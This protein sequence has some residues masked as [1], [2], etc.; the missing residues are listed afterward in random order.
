M[1]ASR[2]RPLLSPPSQALLV[3]LSF[4]GIYLSFPTANYSYDA[5]GYVGFIHQGTFQGPGPGA[6]HPYHVLYM[7]MGIALGRTVLALGVLPDVLAMMQIVNALFAAATLAVFFAIVRAETGRPAA[8]LVATGLL[9]FAYSFWYY[10][11][12]PEVYPPCL[13]FL[14]L[15]WSCARREGVAAAAASGLCFGVASGFH[16]AA[17]AIAPAIAVA[18]LAP[19]PGRAPRLRRLAAA[20]A[21]VLVVGLAPYA[22][23]FHLREGTTLAAGLAR[24][25]GEAAS[26]RSESGEAWFLGRG[27]HPWMEAQGTLAGFS[28][29]LPGGPLAAAGTVLRWALAG[30][31]ILVALH[32]PSLWRR[33]RTAT[34]VLAL[35]FASSFV[36]FTAY[37]VGSLKFVSFH[38]IPLLLLAGLTL[39]RLA[40]RPAVGA[41]V[42]P[43]GAGLVGLLLAVNLAGS[44]LPGMRPERNLPYRRAL[45]VRDRTEAA[46]L[47][48]QAGL[49]ENVELKVYLPYFAARRAVS[50]DLLLRGREP[51]EALAVLDAAIRAAAAGGGRAFVLSDLLDDPAVQRRFGER[52]RLS[53]GALTSFFARYR[54][55]PHASAEDSFGLYELAAPAPA[56]DRGAGR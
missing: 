11:T 55:R 49:G 45:F 7:P 12:D 26:R 8:A 4:L 46:D 21:A 32:G 6:W 20:G 25:A 33:H 24:L 22:V 38:L 16:L 1:T 41:L 17:V 42:L 43:A 35:W 14:L 44:I 54:P 29:V 3:A 27:F 50:L 53:P 19:G 15:A 56:G 2:R 51:A 30:L 9:G 48:I 10:A 28:P 31:A 40:A 47:V 36:L 34:A 52:H 23:Q 18:I 13:L 39:P 37:N 5:I